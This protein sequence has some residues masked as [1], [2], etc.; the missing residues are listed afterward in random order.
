MTWLVYRAPDGSAWKAIGETNPHRQKPCRVLAE[1][2]GPGPRNLLL[3]FED[4]T[5]IVTVHRKKSVRRL[6]K[7]E[8]QKGLF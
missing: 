1:G 6:F 4:G 2:K 8:Q 3:E 5:R 7:T